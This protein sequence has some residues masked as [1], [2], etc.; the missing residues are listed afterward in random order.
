MPDTFSSLT[1]ESKQ[2]YE[3][4]LL[5]RAR[6]AQ[7]FYQYGMKTQ[8]KENS[9]NSV[10]WRRFN[11]LSSA[12]TPLSEGTTPNATSLSVS[13]ITASVQ[14]Y[15]NYVSITDALDL[16]AI[17][18][19]MLE[20]SDVL[21]QNAGESIEIVIRNVLQAG[22]NVQF[23]TGS[24]R[25]AQS[26]ANPLSLNLLRKALIALD[27]N[28]ARRFNA[29]EEADKPGVGGYVAF[30]HPNVVFDIYNDP[31]LKAVLQQNSNNDKF[32]TGY[33]GSIYGIQLYQSTLVPVFTGAG[34]ASANVYATIILGQHAF[35]VVDVSGKGKY[36]LIVKPLGSAGADDPLDQRGS[37]GWKAWQ[38]PVIL[39]NNFMVRIETGSTFG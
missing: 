15:G 9:G 8:L 11:S 33:I 18:K 31:E 26:G 27:A 38:A 21:G 24:T 16:M 37:I 10:S 36:E 6:Q 39:N 1:A 23:A 34:A 12:I 22:T 28:N 19:V 20:A 7:V 25:A 32:W 29:S 14:E 35:G 30:V 3:R 17:D 4:N 2:F 13:E 5:L